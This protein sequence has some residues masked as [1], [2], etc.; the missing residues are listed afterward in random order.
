MISSADHHS[1]PS[2]ESCIAVRDAL[3]WVILAIAAAAIVAIS[4]GFGNW[5]VEVLG[6]V[7]ISASLG[8]V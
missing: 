8:R 1:N 6:S 5:P 7:V 3:P 4:G 2:R